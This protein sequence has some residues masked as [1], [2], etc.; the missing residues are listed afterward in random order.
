MIIS[1]RVRHPISPVGVCYANDPQKGGY[2]ALA[3]GSLR[4]DFIFTHSKKNLKG[5]GTSPGRGR[6][7]QAATIDRIF[8]RCFWCQWSFWAVRTNEPLLGPPPPSGAQ[9]PLPH[10]VANLFSTSQKAP[11]CDPLC[12]AEGIDSVI[13]A[14][15]RGAGEAGFSFPGGGGSIEPSGRTPPSPK[16][17]SIDRTPKILP[18][19]TP[20]PW[21]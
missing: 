14:G 9:T 16:K 13:S 8:S 11:Y 3:P 7:G 4:S 5:R 20:K 19:L 6:G 10:P 18:S 21:R 2:V 17:G 12:R 15:G 1:Q